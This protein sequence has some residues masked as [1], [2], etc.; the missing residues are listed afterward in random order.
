MAY[1][2]FDFQDDN[3]K[4]R[5]N[6]LPSLL[7]QLAAHS[8][9]CCDAISD[10][11]NAHGKGTR[12]PS[13]EELMSCLANVLQL[14]TSPQHPTY[15]ILDALDEC[16]DSSGVR[17]SRDHVLSFVQELVELR[18]RNLFICVTSR[19]EIDIRK[20]LESLTS[21]D[22]SLH[23]QTGHEGDIARYIN[24][25]VDFI[26]KKR[27]WLDGDKKLVVETLIEKADGM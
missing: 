6:I 19:P 26:A 12:Q 10:V 15:I 20:C 16:P 3:K 14:S 17:S 9:I 2:Y 22:V 4:H 1:F 23:D 25:E 8:T 27:G 24:S 21:L 11:Y 7:A 18:L 13:D 5:H